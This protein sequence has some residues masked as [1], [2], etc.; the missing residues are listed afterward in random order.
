MDIPEEL[1]LSW[2]EEQLDYIDDVEYWRSIMEKSDK[3]EII[4]IKEMEG[5]DEL[6]NDWIKC[7]N[8]FSK[9]DKKAIDAG[10]CKY[11]NFISIVLKKK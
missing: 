4:S 9:N 11:L 7:D 1:L 2:S 8:E 3:C 10:A 6:W 5:N